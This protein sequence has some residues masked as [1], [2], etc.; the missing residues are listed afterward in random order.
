MFV[1]DKLYWVSL[2]VI[3]SVEKKWYN[4]RQKI[5]GDGYVQIHTRSFLL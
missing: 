2:R 4:T 5:G 1:S 3:V